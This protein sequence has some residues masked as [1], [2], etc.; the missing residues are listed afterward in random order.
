MKPEHDF[1]KKPKD[2]ESSD[3]IRYPDAEKEYEEEVIYEEDE[4]DKED[5]KDENTDDLITPSI[6]PVEEKAIKTEVYLNQQNKTKREKIEQLEELNKLKQENERKYERNLSQE[7]KQ[8]FLSTTGKIDLETKKSELLENLDGLLSMID[9][10]DQNY[11]TK[12]TEK[13]KQATSFQELSKITQK[14]TFDKNNQVE[15]VKQAE[16]IDSKR[17][18]LRNMI[19]SLDTNSYHGFRFHYEVWNSKIVKANTMDDLLEIEHMINQYKETSN[20]LD[21]DARN[22]KQK[23]E[24]TDTSTIAKAKAQEAVNKLIEVQK[25]LGADNMSKKPVIYYDTDKE[26]NFS[27]DTKSLRSSK[28]Y[29]YV[30]LKD[31]M[32]DPSKD[33]IPNNILLN[34]INIGNLAKRLGQSNEK[35]KFWASLAYKLGCYSADNI[36]KLSFW[37][38]D[39][40]S[41]L[42]IA[43]VPSA[44]NFATQHPVMASTAIGGFV[45]YKWIKNKFFSVK[46]GKEL[47]ENADCI[48]D[49]KIIPPPQ[50]GRPPLPPNTLTDYDPFLPER[51]TPLQKPPS[52]P[53]MYRKKSPKPSSPPKIRK[54]FKK[55]NQGSPK[56]YNYL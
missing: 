36:K 34:G 49:T 42:I 37:L 15:H 7:S 5:E 25:F 39:F 32:F 47:I 53:A 2:E 18:A 35:G 1:K 40:G 56:E 10:P 21:E 30:S 6:T 4:E 51:M 38:V 31:Y 24:D 44:I 14:L 22:Q 12:I 16:F 54:N 13:I 43:A 17:N 33:A 9:N 29:E 23:S 41:K 48:D 26:K 45:G 11:K 20:I 8:N 19:M 46:T 50:P 27:P 3:T 55:N 28:D 52:F